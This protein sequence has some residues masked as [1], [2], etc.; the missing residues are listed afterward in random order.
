MRANRRLLLLCSLL[1]L[2]GAV[3][4]ASFS[5]VPESH[6]AYEAIEYLRSRSVVQGYADKTYKPDQVL[7]RAEALKFIIAPLVEPEALAH[8]TETAYDDV[9]KGSWFLPYVE[10]ARQ[11]EIIDGPPK[12]ASFFG[13]NTVMKSEFFKILLLA[14]KV[15]PNSYSEIRLPLSSDVTDPNAWFYPYLRYGIASSMTMVTANGT[16]DPSRP[17][18]RA[19]ASQLLFRLLMYR[20]GRRTQAL[21][22]E[23]ETEI[24]LVLSLLEQNNIDQAEYASARA[25]LA[26]RGAHAAKPNEPIVIGALKTTEAFRALVRAYRAGLNEEY[27]EVIRLTKDAWTLAEKAKE[28]AP[29]LEKLII[30]VQNVATTMANTAR[31]AK[32]T[33][34]QNP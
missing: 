16:L 19:D 7:N 18:T 4:A 28:T 24:L 1:L 20:E 25:L 13:G 9:P 32:K 27:D 2:P 21:L 12:K 14:H 22:S 33:S 31:E 30:E 5:D 23:S 34:S 26:A 10:I 6:P 11:A 3:S 29:G 15:D 8:F 17:L